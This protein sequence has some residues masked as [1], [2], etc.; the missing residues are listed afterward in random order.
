MKGM[1]VGPG[2]RWCVY[3]DPDTTLGELARALAA[4]PLNCVVDEQGAVCLQ[5]IG[6]RDEGR[7]S[8]E[9]LARALWGPDNTATIVDE[10]GLYPALRRV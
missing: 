10:S 3:P 8:S 5:M 6:D 2:R 7:P 4:Y 9:E 1:R